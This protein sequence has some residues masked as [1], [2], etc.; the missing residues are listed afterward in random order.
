LQQQQEPLDVAGCPVAPADPKGMRPMRGR[1]R[2]RPREEQPCLEQVPPPSQLSKRGR[3]TKQAQPAS[4]PR[5]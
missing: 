1:P 3:Q 2:K 4:K 5:S